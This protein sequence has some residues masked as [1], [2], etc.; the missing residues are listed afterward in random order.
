[1]VQILFDNKV[2]KPALLKGLT[3]EELWLPNGVPGGYVAVLRK[4]LE[5]VNP[6][7]EG[8]LPV[9][10]SQVWCANANRSMEKVLGGFETTGKVLETLLKKNEKEVEFPD[11][12]RLLSRE[13]VRLSDLFPET[14]WP[15]TNAVSRTAY[16]A[17]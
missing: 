2:K 6:E 12:E 11:L 10:P 13:E 4:V 9:G 3:V 8:A 7:E 5:N 16:H 14:V 15:P 17:V 1:M